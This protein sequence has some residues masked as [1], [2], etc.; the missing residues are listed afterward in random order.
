MYEVARTV[1]GPG[2]DGILI[3]PAG[4]SPHEDCGVI[5]VNAVGVGPVADQPAFMLVTAKVTAPGDPLMSIP[6]QGPVEHAGAV[7]DR[8]VA[9]VAGAAPVVMLMFWLRLK[10]AY[11]RVPVIRTKRTMATR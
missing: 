10:V 5:N 4:L 8:L 9:P 11:A 2:V 6:W 1:K 7:A 3:P